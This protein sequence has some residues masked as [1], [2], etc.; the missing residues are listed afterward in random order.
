MITL[1]SA[2]VPVWIILWILLAHFVAD[3]VF[4]NDYMGTNKSHDNEAL[5][6]HVAVY[7]GIIGLFMTILFFPASHPG[8]FIG[9]LIVTAVLH[10]VT[11]YN[12]SRLTTILHKSFETT[13][14]SRHWFFV[15]IGF[16]QVIHYVCL[17]LAYKAFMPL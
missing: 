13:P 14:G 15:V 9:F 5:G 2:S 10:L 12:T 4:Q 3:F 7:T 1:L 17:F 8:H 11:D 6:W 16:D